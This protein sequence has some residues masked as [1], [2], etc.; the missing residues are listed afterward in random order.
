[1]AFASCRRSNVDAL[2]DLAA[3][4][5]IVAGAFMLLREIILWYWRQ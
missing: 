2:T 4:I 5:I 3:G 1:M